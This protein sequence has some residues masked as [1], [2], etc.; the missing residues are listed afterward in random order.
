MSVLILSLLTLVSAVGAPPT[1]G[2]KPAGIPRARS[3][4]CRA[5]VWAREHIA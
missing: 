5:G 2:Q 3:H 1:S 4:G